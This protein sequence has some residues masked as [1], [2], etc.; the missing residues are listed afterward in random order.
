[1]AVDLLK[2]KASSQEAVSSLVDHCGVS[3]RQA[4]RYVQRAQASSKPLPLPEAKDVFTV[5]LSIGLIERVRQRAR[6]ED[7]A[8]SDMV[9][10]ALEDFLKKRRSHG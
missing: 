10:E 6:R 8:I 7:R 1:M 3:A 9:T 5:K 2:N 4:Y